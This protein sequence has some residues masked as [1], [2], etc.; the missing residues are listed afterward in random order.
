VGEAVLEL[1][2]VPEGADGV[3]EGQLVLVAGIL[4]GCGRGGGEGLADG[5]VVLHWGEVLRVT[6]TSRMFVNSG[7]GRTSTV[8]S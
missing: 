1:V 3:L 4:G 6:R 5:D 8:V 2:V 7:W